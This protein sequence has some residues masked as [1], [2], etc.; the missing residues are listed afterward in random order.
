[1]PQ[2]TV[3]QILAGTTTGR[4]QAAGQMAIIPI[5][6]DGGS[7]DWF[8]PPEFEAG[9]RNYGELRVRNRSSRET[10]LPTGAAFLTSQ[11]AQDHAAP[12]AMVL[13][14]AE[15]SQI[16]NAYCVQETQGGY[17][18]Q[19]A[20]DF[21]ILPAQLR[22]YALAHRTQGKYDAMWPHIRAFKESMGLRG[23]GNLADFLKRF[24]KE[25]EQFVAEFELV[26]RQVGALILIAG[27][28]VGI[29]R[30]PSEAFWERLWNPLVRVC[31]GSLALREAARPGIGLPPTRQ[32]LTGTIG[33]LEALSRALDAASEV[34][35]GLVIATVETLLPK[36]LT[37][38]P[39]ADQVRG[40]STVLTLASQEYAGQVVTRANT[41]VYA[42]ICAA[43]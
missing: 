6:D 42:S 23:A 10:I 17:I 36:A 9:T 39:Q 21:L 15:E 12:G 37:S 25:L 7:G 33:S 14:G 43:G 2:L 8:A 3:Q 35:K 1:M 11:A 30:A 26:P 40:Q 27:K 20:R 16:S 19:E 41:P 18:R 5:L 24:E 29:E 28:L 4:L 38:A 13:A 32:P 31:Y 22:A 34:A